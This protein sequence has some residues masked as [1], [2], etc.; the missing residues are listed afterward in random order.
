[1][2][3]HTNST[4]QYLDGPRIVAVAVA[5]AAAPSWL[6]LGL[7]APATSLGGCSLARAD[8]RRAVPARAAPPAVVLPRPRRVC[9]TP[10]PPS[11]RHR[12][13]PRVVPAAASLPRPRTGTTLGLVV[14]GDVQALPHARPRPGRGRQSTP[15][16]PY[17]SR[18]GSRGRRACGPRAYASRRGS[19][20]R[21]T[22]R[23]SRRAQGGLQGAFR[24]QGWSGSVTAG[25]A[26]WGL[27]LRK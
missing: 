12:P 10:L 21:R 9:L 13:Q 3:P 25:A 7:S 6:P 19:R 24:V 15:R 23:F 11:P 22:L 14:A 27:L 20:R 17:V 1:M 8:R 18:R 5:A 26:R 4:V 2:F 16:S